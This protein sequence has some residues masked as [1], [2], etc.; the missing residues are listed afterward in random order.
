MIPVEMVYI[1][2]TLATGLSIYAVWHLDNRIYANIVLG[3]FTSSVLWF[4]LA[5]N[6]VTEN[7]FYS[8]SNTSGMRGTVLADMPLF[9]VFVLFGVAMSIYTLVLSIEAVMERNIKDI[10]GEG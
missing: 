7:V 9:W 1:L 6:V 3:G 2:T 10:G 4:F 5:A 8:V